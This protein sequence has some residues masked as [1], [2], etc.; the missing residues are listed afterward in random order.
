MAGAEFELLLSTAIGLDAASIGSS[1]IERAVQERQ[2]ALAL[3][4]R[5][6]YWEHV[7]ASGTELQALVEA[8]VVPETSFFRHR[9]AFSALA[10]IG[11]E[12]WLQAPARMLRLLSLPS[13]TGEEP[14]SIAMALLDAGVP[15]DRFRVDAVDV[16]SRALAR[17]ESAEYGKNSFRGTDLVFRGRHFDETPHG[18]LLRDNVRGQVHFRQGNLFATDFLPGLE[19]YD[20]V[21]CRNLLIYFDRPTQ[22]RAVDILERLLTSNGTL[23]VGPS[24]TAVLLQHDLVSTKIPM[25]FAFRKMVHR[26]QKTNQTADRPVSRISRPRPIV[27]AAPTQS[28]RTKLQVA[29]LQGPPACS[30][31]VA[32]AETPLLALSLEEA[33]K[34]ADQ[35]RFVEAAERCEECLRQHGPSAAGFHLLGLVH[36]ATGKPTDASSYYRKALYLDPEHYESLVHLAFLVEQQGNG[37]G[38]HVLRERARRAEQT[39][40]T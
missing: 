37:E 34:L 6:V 23:F 12:H 2:S 20:V 7:R 17:A 13:S 22:D 28:A 11:Q 5:Q 31:K 24:E 1:A 32:P 33:I 10:R 36:D 19:L 16:S 29:A 4:D 9:E 39:S 18:Y 8:V 26:A 40:R 14:Y 3:P 38:A 25:A 15:P 30:P 35:G 27:T 21:F